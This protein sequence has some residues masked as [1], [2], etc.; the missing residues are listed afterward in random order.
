M[1]TP[2]YIK[3]D[4]DARLSIRE[5]MEKVYRA[6]GMTLGARGRSAAVEQK[7]T[8]PT[9]TFDG[10][11]VAKEIVLE[12]PFE[13]LGADLIKQVADKTNESV[14]DGTTTSVILSY[15]LID[16]G[17]KVVKE[18]GFNVIRLA[19]EIKNV[20]SSV[21]KKLSE[22]AVEVKDHQ[23]I[24]EVATLSSKNEA[25]GE[26]IAEVMERVG[27]DGVV[28]LEDSS[29]LDSRYEEVEGLRIDRGYI[30]PYFV[31]KPDNMTSELVNP[32]VLIANQR[33]SIAADIVP[34]LTK[35]VEK[36]FKELVIVADEVDGEALATLIT[37]HL[38][39]AIRVVVLQSPSFG[40][41]RKEELGDM[42]TFTGA[43][44]ISS[45]LG[46]KLSEVEID[47]LGKVRKV[48]TTKETS[49][50]ID[51]GG[52]P[53]EISDRI[54]SI[55]SQLAEAK[56]DY[57]KDRLTDRLSRL[58]GGVAII[59]V[60]GA[61][62]SEQKE[63]KQRF[64]DAVSATKAA[65][66]EGIVPGGGIALY[67]AFHAL[68]MPPEGSVGSEAY[69]IV[70]MACEAPLRSILANCGAIPEL[71]LTRLPS[72]NIWVGFDAVGG[73]ITDLRESGIVDPLKVTRT[74]LMNAVSV[75]ANYLTIGVAIVEIPKVEKV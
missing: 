22:Q 30:S 72:D 8:S 53:S 39:G 40:D 71:V 36:G 48:I 51:G 74:A 3:F 65:M 61:T 52:N 41:R 13:N 5:G 14:G 16:E 9:I 28:T 47:D 32:F 12:D 45:E 25:V 29:T 66:L 33:I 67:R 18:K 43:K 27:K 60:G 63:L 26:L 21:V 24:Q 34:L 46:R 42:A 44:I 58:Q 73:E 50:F 7:F 19:E 55:K 4:D 11:S 23:Q 6:V 15:R 54:T 1:A 20:A 62:E 2:R 17:E 37:N 69:K 35:M 75:A 31:T 68:E 64:E 10:V 59:Y 49:T 38:R 70:G 57:D 56:S